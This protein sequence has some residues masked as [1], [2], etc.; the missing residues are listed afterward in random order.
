MRETYSR[1][2]QTTKDFCVDDGTVST[3]ELSSTALF[4][5]NQINNTISY[6]YQK[7]KNYKT[8]SLPYTLSTVADQIYYHYPPRTQSV[9]SAVVTVGDINYP[10]TIIHS[11]EHWD[12]LQQTTV[13][14][15]TI[16]LYA[17]P[18]QYDFGIYPTPDAAYTTTL[19][20][21]QLPSRLSVVDESQGT[22]AVS[23]NGTTV[24]G[25]NTA[26]TS[27]MVGRWFCITDTDGI[28]TGNWYKVKTYSSSTSISLETVFEESSVSG[29]RY[30]IGQSPEIPEELHEYI[31]YRAAAI[32]YS[33][34]RREPQKAQELLNFFYT[35]DFTKTSRTGKMDGGVLGVVSEYKHMGRGSSPINM[36]GKSV[37]GFI[38]P[39]Q[40][41]WATTLTE[42]T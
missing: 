1:L 35:G 29:A 10:L 4:L 8:Q 40:E 42:A 33:T 28:P 37:K 21:N 9:V 16:P 15:S 34:M 18:R 6:L 36:M 12:K 19:L 14:A 22:I 30:V 23:Q 13:A 41:A 32:Y 17:F 24:T 26:F 27:A 20:V 5:A 3:T 11:Q 38:S 39:W 2:L 25:T 7:I 31:P